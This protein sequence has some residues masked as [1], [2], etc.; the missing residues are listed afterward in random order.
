MMNVK[1][2]K[3]R[4]RTIRTAADSDGGLSSTYV[5]HGLGSNSRNG[6]WQTFTRDLQAD[7]QE[8]ESDN[9][10][11]SIDGFLIRGTGRVDD[12]TT[13]SPNSQITIYED[14][15]QLKNTQIIYHLN[16]QNQRVAKEVN[17]VITKKY[18]WQDLTTLLAT[19][20]PDDT[21]KQRFNYASNRM[22]I[23]MTQDNQTYYLSYD[24]VG[25]LRLVTD[26]QNNII[27]EI[28]YDT[29][30]NILNDTNRDLEIP[31]GFAG[32]M[33][34]RDT[35]LVHFGYR[36]YDPFTGKWTAKDPIGFDGGD[37]NLYG[38]VLND[39]VNFIDPEGLMSMRMPRGSL[40][41]PSPKRPFPGYDPSKSPF[42]GFEWRGKPNSKPGDK[43]GNYYNP[44]TGES[45]RPDLDHPKP[46]GPHWDYKSPAGEWYRIHPDGSMVPKGVVP[47]SPIP[48]FPIPRPLDA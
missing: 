32:G 21:L 25:S 13:I 5:H 34:D 18:L 14:A 39:P 36:E 33:H 15:E 20:N 3:P 24:Q 16:A 37:A 7:L 31:F 28:T 40:R 10:I 38:Y 29:F 30:G 45:C 48:N 6:S 9:E 46:I 27:K 12:I 4:T 44:K 2:Y 35:E 43:N 17:G 26:T 19:Y 1:N 8:F 47:T 23:S 41:L 22:P 42:K 11:I